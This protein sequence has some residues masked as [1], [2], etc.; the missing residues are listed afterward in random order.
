MLVELETFLTG[1]R[2][3]RRDRPV[4]GPEA[5]TRR[6]R[7]V[8]ALA[9]QGLSAQ[10]LGRRLGIGERTAETHLANAYAKLGIRSRLELVRRAAEF[11]L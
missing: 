5:L 10:G 9:V 3:D 2:R 8:A 11:G 1:R 4:A 7:E 6:E